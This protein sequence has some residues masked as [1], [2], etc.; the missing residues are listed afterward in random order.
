MVGPGVVTGP[1]SHLRQISAFTPNPLTF[2]VPLHWRNSGLPC[3]RPHRQRNLCRDRPR[4]SSETISSGGGADGAPMDPSLDEGL[5]H[6]GPLTRRRSTETWD[7]HEGDRFGSP[8]T[9]VSRTTHCLHTPHTG[10][11]RNLGRYRPSSSC[12]IRGLDGGRDLGRSKPPD[13][14]SKR[15]GA[16]THCSPKCPRGK[17]ESP[18][19]PVGIPPSSSLTHV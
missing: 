1:R 19:P 3:C 6:P 16:L 13:R 10:G 18:R 5:P 14:V 8:S 12:P 2:P 11:G 15:A 9:P 4:S 17:L 7:D